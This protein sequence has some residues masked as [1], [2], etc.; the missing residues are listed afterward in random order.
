M[1]TLLL[2]PICPLVALHRPYLV[3]V[4]VGQAAEMCFMAGLHPEPIAIYY[5]RF[6]PPS[7]K[8]E[9][10]AARY[11]ALAQLLQLCDLAPRHRAPATIATAPSS[12]SVMI[13]T[14]IILSSLVML[15]LST[16]TAHLPG[17]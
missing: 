11:V 13:V 9:V 12:V 15:C 4:L 3:A 16:R 17:Q 5:S 7:N 14:M 6:R 8:Q 1:V 2:N 10:E